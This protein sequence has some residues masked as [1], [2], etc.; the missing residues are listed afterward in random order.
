MGGSAPPNPAPLAAA[1]VR[2]E[3]HNE[4]ER[5]GTIA[6]KLQG[7]HR[8]IEDPESKIAAF[9]PLRAITDQNMDQHTESG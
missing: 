3:R 9:H 2:G 1:G 6:K 4:D 5:F 7:L 8:R